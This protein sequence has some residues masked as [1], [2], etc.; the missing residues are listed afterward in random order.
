VA[1]VFVSHSS[2]DN[3]VAAEIMAWLNS[4]GFEEVFLDIDKHAGI[5]PGANWERELYRK[6]DSAQ[7]MIL[8]MTPAWHE[9]KWC[10]VEFAQARA[11]GKA[12]FPVIV[13]PGGDRFIAPD[14]QQLD[15]MRDREGGLE[16]LA[17]ELTR[18]ALDS[19]AGF[20]WSPGR[21]PYPG[22]MAFEKEGAAVF[23]GREDDVRDLIERL[24]AKRVRGGVGF[25][26][27]L[28]A[29]GSGKSSVLRAGV[30]PR[31]ERDHANWIV[32]PP[33]RPRRD[34]EAEF[35]RAASDLLGTPNEW[36]R[37]AEAFRGGDAVRVVDDLV[38][39]ARIKAG[40]REATLLV[41]IDQ[42]EELFS[43]A[44]AEEASRLLKTLLRAA[45]GDVAIVVV[46]ALRSDYLDKLQ[47]AACLLR[48]DEF[49]LRPFPLARVRQIIEGPA[50]VAGLRVEEGLIAAAM[51]D[52]GDDDA[53]PL[54]A[55]MLRE[56]YARFG[57]SRTEGLGNVELSLAHYHMLG[58]AE[59]GLNPLENAVRRRADEVIDG[60]R[61]SDDVLALLREVFVGS[62][63]RI[64]EDGRYARRPAPWDD[65]PAPV[66]PVLEKLAQARLMVIRHEGGATTVEV[67]HEALLRKWTLVRGWL[68]AERDFLV[69][70]VQLRFALETWRTT[71]RKQEALLQGL[72]LSRARQSLHD[73]KGALSPEERDFIEASIARDDAERAARRRR[74]WITWSG[75]AML[76]LIGIIAGFLWWEQQATSL[77]AEAA[78]LAVQARARL[79]TD[80]VEA[81]TWAAQ[82]V[83]KQSS[84]DTLSVLLE[85]TLAISPHL[86]Q[87]VRLADLQPGAIA[88]SGD[89]ASLLLTDQHGRVFRWRAAERDLQ[90]LSAEGER[91][92][93]SKPIALTP[94]VLS[95][96]SQD[97][98]ALSVSEDGTRRLWTLRER[99]PGPISLPNVRSL[100]HA[101]VGSDGGV[102]AS[103]EE[104]EAVTL[105]TCHLQ[106]DSP[107]PACTAEHV[108]Q[109]RATA[110]AWNDAHAL[111]A[112][113][114]EN[115]R[116]TLAGPGRSRRDMGPEIGQSGRATAL[117]FSPD[118]SQLAIGTT[119]GEVI[120]ADPSGQVLARTH[121]PEAGSIMTLAWAPG[122]RLLVGACGTS[123]VC[124]WNV[125]RDSGLAM[126]SRLDGH[127]GTVRAVAV[128]P[129]GKRV[130]SASVDGT[131]RLWSLAS[132]PAFAL[133]DG[134]Q[135]ETLTA[136]D[137][138]ADQAFLA[139]G[140]EA[141]I[142]HLWRLGEQFARSPILKA[143]EA[144][145]M[146]LAWS[147]DGTALAAATAD[148]DVSV[149]RSPWHEVG[150]RFGT[151][152]RLLALRWLPDASALLTAGGSD[153]AIEVRLP[154][155]RSLP[156][157]M[158]AHAESVAGLAVS[159]D[160][161]T[162]LS[163][164]LLGKVQAWRIPTRSTAGPPIETHF[165]RDTIAY[166]RDG[167]RY[168]VAGNGG[169]VVIYSSAAG[170]EAT[171]CQ[172]G[173]DQI[174][175]AAFSPDGQ[176][177]A[178]LSRDAVFYIW[179]FGGPC[180][181]LASAHLPTPR[182][183]AANAAPP[184]AHRPQ[185]VFGPGPATVSLIRSTQQMFKISTDPNTWLARVARL[186]GH[187]TP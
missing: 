177:V 137:L 58:D 109:G 187:K 144:P 145:V 46:L 94:Q 59:S 84:A 138:S 20:P 57:T 10:F 31:I 43:V 165:S 83:E 153:G 142:V 13:A 52:M 33:F 125:A 88:W 75:A 73:H 124:I 186:T 110:L 102:L 38:T 126:S 36:R 112:I 97:D 3:A 44:S 146:T 121:A 152:T 122:A 81:A 42:G 154:D 162:L 180:E 47:A 92:D 184:S 96:A 149:A 108:D 129:D 141:G 48:F 150:D 127:A 113:G 25:L 30:L 50:R 69:G 115:G 93:V 105:F 40:Q 185:L 55:F 64:D 45:D 111:A 26:A 107:A 70:K 157:F 86:A 181:L 139:A 60:L 176:L 41:T 63:V 79:A 135:G 173:S 182:A 98:T 21:S 11:L 171:S 76:V 15:L 91:G 62:L 136:L 56:L 34:P 148:G 8:I 71:E 23:F 49:S 143:M 179:R 116:V 101:A 19:Q 123:S 80:P 53:L 1:R 67:A 118:G 74:Q 72:A 175:A 54:L 103:D 65:V 90:S 29:S 17:R 159:P 87:L 18:L 22:L 14:I 35:A 174:D 167:S 6:I 172:S 68:D 151:G 183:F 82:A 106:P 158:N 104:T 117:A 161:T 32:C 51:E 119:D 166:T 24:N 133:L 12:I 131:A 134:G 168:L 178:A 156:G 114:F 95:L 7:A 147:P 85:S 37:W 130:A 5:P 89:G 77:R 128:S 9:S 78:R 132:D 27:V 99:G 28:G 120:I 140:D 163:A 160:G 169:A 39:D 2:R 16:R 4:G 164:D 61:L 100:T 66:C 170:P 155:G